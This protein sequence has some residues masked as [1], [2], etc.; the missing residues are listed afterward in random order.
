MKLESYA[1]R[2]ALLAGDTA[3]AVRMLADYYGFPNP[4]EVPV[5]VIG[6]NSTAYGSDDTRLLFWCGDYYYEWSGASGFENGIRWAASS[7]TS[8]SARHIEKIILWT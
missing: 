6:K 2:E 3:N 1:I 4:I 7:M 5:T 8:S